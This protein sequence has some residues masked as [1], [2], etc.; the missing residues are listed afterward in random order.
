LVR[1]YVAKFIEFAIVLDW[2]DAALLEMYRKGLKNDVKDELIRYGG[3]I[4][5]LGQIIEATS[6]IRD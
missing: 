1:D 6:T 4:D 3:R 5:T 2:G